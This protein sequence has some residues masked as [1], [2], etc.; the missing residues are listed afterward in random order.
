VN[1]IRLLAI[2]LA[3]SPAAAADVDF[4][5]DVQPILAAH[6]AA[7]HG[8]D[9]KARK[10][11]LRLDIRGAKVIV[12]GKPDESQLI[13]RLT[14]DDDDGRMPPPKIGPRLTP[15]QIRTLR[16]WIEQGA[17]YTDHWAFV[18]PRRP[19][20]PTNAATDPI[21]AFLLDRLAKEGLKPAPRAARETLIRRAT[22][23][24]I[25]LP[26]TPTEVEAFV[27]DP[28]P[29][30]WEKVIDR[31]LASRRTGSGGGGTGST[32]PGT[33]TPAGSRLTSSTAP[34]GGTATT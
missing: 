10:A 4:S 17:N 19:T 6:C 16:T 21:D 14:A 5:R 2:V 28:S 24:L 22:F 31:L 15:E 30:A 23:D 7:C 8:P 18:P 3:A 29:A 33:P 32:S 20:V 26:P 25:G 13:A 9:A 12:P 34:P 27:T 1:G 11:D